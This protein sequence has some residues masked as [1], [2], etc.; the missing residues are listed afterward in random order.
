MS[1]DTAGNVYVTGHTASTNFPVSQNAFDKNHSGSGGQGVGDDVFV[2]KFDSLLTMLLA[3]TYLG[4]SAWENGYA[5]INDAQGNVYV[6][7]TTSSTNF[8]TGPNAYDKTYDGGTSIAGDIFISKFTDDLSALSASTYLGKK[9][10]EST[11]A[12]CIDSNENLLIA[13]ST[14]SS[15]FPTTY[16]SYNEIYNG[17]AGDIFIVRLDS[18]LSLDP[19]QAKFHANPLT[20]HAPLIV[21]FTDSST[22]IQPITSWKWDFN[23]DG[24]YD[25]QEQNTMDTWESPV[26]STLR[27]IWAVD[28]RN[29][30]AVGDGA[31]VSRGLIQASVSGVIA[32]REISKRIL[33]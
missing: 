12:L 13:G 28:S 33:G 8:P 20:G 3:S 27:A 29:F 14:A 26:S 5:I 19:V 17:G 11:G 18:L 32:A 1:L 6:T 22:A 9:Q 2:S 21:Q 25:S 10:K 23:H 16:G 31:G 24:I 4:G 30:F 15:D 7:G